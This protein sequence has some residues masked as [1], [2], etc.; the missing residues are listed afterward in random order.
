[1]LEHQWALVTALLVRIHVVV[2]LVLK[3][4]MLLLQLALVLLH[5]LSTAGV[6]S[7]VVQVHLL[8]NVHVVF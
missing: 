5:L 6:V 8:L 1:M 3:L 2:V 7:H 4:L